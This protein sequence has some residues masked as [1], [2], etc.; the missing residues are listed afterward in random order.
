MGKVLDKNLCFGQ[1]RLINNDDRLWFKRNVTK[2]LKNRFN[3]EWEFMFTQS[4]RLMFGDF[5]VPGLDPRVYE[6]VVNSE[7]PDIS[8]FFLNYAVCGI[9]CGTHLLASLLEISLVSYKLMFLVRSFVPL[10]TIYHV[11][12]VLSKAPIL[13]N[14]S[15]DIWHWS[16]DD[17]IKDEIIFGAFESL[18]QETSLYSRLLAKIKRIP[19][20][21]PK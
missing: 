5:L 11:R 3:M 21:S 9:W 17:Y 7:I 12:E 2:Q 10:L 4:E 19:F 1:D 8:W 16:R 14:W 18:T 15:S 13:V 20:I 6:Q